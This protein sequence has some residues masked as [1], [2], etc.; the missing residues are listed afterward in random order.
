MA[1][2]ADLHIE[3]EIIPLFDFTFNLFSGKEVKRLIMELPGNLQETEYR[4]Q[5]LKGFIANHEIWKEYSF[6]R[7]NLSEIHDFFQ[8][9]GEGGFSAKKLKWKLRFSEKERSRR[10]GR[11]ILLV[12][13]F[14]KMQQD[15]IGKLDT[16]VFPREYEREL[17]LLNRF[18]LDFHLAHYEKIY[19]KRKR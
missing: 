15:Y 9:F 18:F 4:Q 17:D 5:V 11:L 1:N 16:K 8:T 2:T 14:S 12:R 7:F 13:L 3:E 6:S 10:R 19:E